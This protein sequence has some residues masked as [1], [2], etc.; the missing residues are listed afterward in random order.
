MGR[1]ESSNLS[2][3]LQCQHYVGLLFWADRFLPK[4][5]FHSSN[6]PLTEQVW[7]SFLGARQG[8]HHSV[9]RV[10]LTSTIVMWCLIQHLHLGWCLSQN[11]SSSTQK[12]CLQSYARF[13]VQASFLTVWYRKRAYLEVYVIVPNKQ[14][15]LLFSALPRVCTFMDTCH[16]DFWT[17]Q[18][19]SMWISL[20]LVGVSPLPSCRSRDPTVS[21]SLMRYH[22]SIHLTFCRTE[23]TSLICPLLFHSDCTCRAMPFYLC[24]YHFHGF[25]ERTK[26]ITY[27]MHCV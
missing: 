5:L 2:G 18:G 15:I 23:L 22:P 17:F 10:S 3:D 9:Y 16:L 8:S 27:I 21:S 11:V 20:L 26:I 19:F 25:L 14:L 13:G 24:Y 6:F 1:Q 7:L 12:M 4:G